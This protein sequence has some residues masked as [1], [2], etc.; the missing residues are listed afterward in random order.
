MRVIPVLDI[1][2]GVVVHAAGGER[3]AYRPI[4]TPLAAGADPIDVARGLLAVYP[5][6]AIYIAD[7]DGIAGKGRNHDSICSLR[8]ELPDLELWIDDGSATPQA[9]AALA[10]MARVRPVA[11]SETLTSLASLAPLAEAAAGRLILSLD[12]KDGA[13]LGPPGLDA[14]ADLWPDTVIA[15][16]LARVGTN[17]GPDLE[18]IGMLASRS[19]TASIVAAGGV[20]DAGDLVALATAGAVGVLVASALHA[21]RIEADDIHRV[22]GLAPFSIPS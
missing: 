19:T 2:G 6:E 20:R 13:A 7:L 8:A 10:R 21:K 4:Q 9:I 1:K 16:T 17:R 3:D 11:G 12:S 14:R 15:M 18:R 5:F 22:T